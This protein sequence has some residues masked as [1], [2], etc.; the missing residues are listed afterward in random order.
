MAVVFL[1]TRYAGNCSGNELLLMI[2]EDFY[3]WLTYALTIFIT[4]IVTKFLERRKK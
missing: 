2:S 4:Y 1:V 3:R